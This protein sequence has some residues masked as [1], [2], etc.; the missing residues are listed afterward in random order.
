[1]FSRSCEVATARKHEID[2]GKT[3]LSGS[4]YASL[5][6]E[7]DGVRDDMSGRRPANA[8][9]TRHPPDRFRATN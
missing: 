4:G 8:T 3:S 5:E 7:N 6:K 2:N 1:V 9:E